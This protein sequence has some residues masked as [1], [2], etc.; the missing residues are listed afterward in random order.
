MSRKKLWVDVVVII[1]FFSFLLFYQS[2]ATTLTNW[3]EAWFASVAQDSAFRGDLWGRWNGQVW[4]YE[5]PLLT[6]ILAI[7]IDI[8]LS[9][10]GWLRSVNSL[11]G[12]ATLVLVYFFS[13]H[14]SRSRLAG[15]ISV[16]IL[17]SDIEFLFRSR[18]INVEVPLTLFLFLTLYAAMRM[19]SSTSLR[20]PVLAGVSMGLALLTKRASPLLIVPALLVFVA[21]LK[22]AHKKHVVLAGT[23]CL[24]IA[25][26]WYIASLVRWGGQFFNE[27]FIGYTFGKIRSINPG[28]G[29]NPL[30]Y[31]IALK[32]AFKFWCLPILITIGWGAM[33]IVRQNSTMLPIVV[34][35]LTFF[36]FLTIAPMKSSWFLLPIHPALAM[37]TGCWIATI[38]KHWKFAKLPV[39]LLL[40]GVACWQIWYFRS[41]YIV[42][43][44]TKR[45]E[46]LAKIVRNLT[47]K[48]EVIY[49]DDD[50][51]P[52]AVFYSQRRVVA[53][54]FNRNQPLTPVPIASGSYI[55]SHQEL[56]PILENHYPNLSIVSRSSDLLLLRYQ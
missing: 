42:P 6:W 26:P 45:Q 41:D 25:S 31:L 37:V 27:F 8:G 44:T 43:D 46:T 35:I 4:F 56:L 49:L 48:G 30:F 15:L 18:Q 53:L 36:I 16:F 11:S 22:K 47:Q 28:A 5:P 17:G 50:Y 40:F 13:Y 55:L 23:I 12:L 51:L 29:A 38:F 21:M 24:A 14:V 20:W 32:H 54:R 2:G 7:L 34:F 33:S 10:E 1:S 3:D 52:V 9:G 39:V 19:L